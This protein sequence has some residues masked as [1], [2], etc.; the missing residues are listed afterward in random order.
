MGGFT[1]KIFELKR[2]FKYGFFKYLFIISEEKFQL[3][4][5]LGE[6]TGDLNRLHVLELLKVPKFLHN[7]VWYIFEWQFKK[8]SDFINQMVMKKNG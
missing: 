1:M 8:H 3:E 5:H 6:K 4:T 2:F 7:L